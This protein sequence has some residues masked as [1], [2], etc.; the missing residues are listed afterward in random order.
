VTP[1]AT[2]QADPKKALIDS[3]GGIVKTFVKNTIDSEVDH[4][5]TRQYRDYLKNHYYIRGY[6]YLKP[7]LMSGG[8]LTIQGVLGKTTGSQD[9]AKY[10]LNDTAGDGKKWVGLL[11]TKAPHAEVSPVDRN[12]EDDIIAAKHVKGALKSIQKQID[13]DSLQMELANDLWE[14]GTTLIFTD[15]VADA[16]KFGETSVPRYRNEMVELAPNRYECPGCGGMTPESDDPMLD[17]PCEECGQPLTLADFKEAQMAELPIEDGADT[18]PNGGLICH[19]C[20]VETIGAPFAFKGIKAL[21]WIDYKYE[22]HTSTLLDLFGDRLREHIGEDEAPADSSDTMGITARA[23]RSSPSASQVGQKNMLTFRRLWLRPRMYHMFKKAERKQL[24]EQFPAGLKVSVVNDHVMDLEDERMDD[25]WAVCQP[26]VSKRFWNDAVC[27]LMIQGNDITDDMLNIQVQT[28][29]RSNAITLLN[30]SVVDAKTLKSRR[31]NPA[32]IIE[33]KPDYGGRLADAAYTIQRSTLDPAVPELFGKI[34]GYM[35]EN[36]GIV[37]EVFGGGQGR[38]TWRAEEQAKNQALQMLL[39]IWKMMQAAWREAYDNMVRL[40]L[41]FEMQDMK[42]PDG[43]PIDLEA[44]RRGKYK[45]EVE[46]WFPITEGQLAERMER[47]LESAILAEK[48]PWF[49]PLNVRITKERMGWSDLQF[50]G[51]NEREKM[52]DEIRQLLKEEP[53]Q[54]PGEMGAIETR[55]SIAPRNAEDDH[56]LNVQV[57]KEWFQIPY[58]VRMEKEN[59]KGYQNVLARFLAEQHLVQIEMAKQAAL[60]PAGEP[61]PGGGGQTPPSPA[62]PGGAA[63]R[64]PKPPSP[65]VPGAAGPAPATHM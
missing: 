50:P 28:A 23:Q 48:V 26:T 36:T 62:A 24:F 33:A 37:P 27:R 13:A 49:H 3:L 53:V 52:L 10:V 31:S 64:R 65:T 41:Q 20:T 47:H 22:E 25:H 38:D 1:T 14:A 51:E 59:P 58:A 12:N 7:V 55:P 2:K 19:M 5:R 29:E 17:P 44:V 8:G 42:D 4:E 35:R 21:P 43:E 15:Y 11:G 54:I 39:P 30:P 16:D 63:P 60:A 57:I 56:E 34:R 61:Q 6:H 32:D 46:S 45:I 18:F 9:D 40:L